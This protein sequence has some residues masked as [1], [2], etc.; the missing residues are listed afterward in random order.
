MATA[1]EFIQNC[2][3]V[4]VATVELAPK[5]ISLRRCRHDTSIIYRTAIAHVLAAQTG[6]PASEIARAL[7]AS[8]LSRPEWPVDCYAS[9]LP[10]AEI[11]CS[12]SDRAISTW[13]QR[14]LRAPVLVGVPVPSQSLD[15]TLASPQAAVDLPRS[16]VATQYA[17]DRCRS[18]LEMG[19]RAGAIALKWDAAGNLHWQQ[20]HPMPWLIVGSEPARLNLHA[21]AE[22][23]LLGQL[24]DAI[25][26]LESAEFANWEQLA[27]TLGTAALNLHRYCRMWGDVEL[28]HA[29]IRLGCLAIAYQLLNAL[30]WRPDEAGKLLPGRQSA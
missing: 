21:P 9:A 14:C 28:A 12:P 16:I 19:A 29:R 10:T 17:R 22:R 26:A 1:W 30:L 3:Q 8:V 7:T 6:Y 25:D 11:V 27:L 15:V 18:L 23:Q 2:L 20:P 13:L 4:Q 5:R 24:L